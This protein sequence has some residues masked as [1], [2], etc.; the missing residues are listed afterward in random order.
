MFGED[1]AKNVQEL[2]AERVE[3]ELAAEKVLKSLA[4]WDRIPK[5]H[6]EETPKRFLEALHQL[7]DRQDFNF[8]MFDANGLDEMIT[9]GPI[10]FYTLCAHHVVPFYGNVWIGYV[11]NRRIAGLSKFARTVK[12]CAKG[13]W[14]QEELTVEIANFLDSRLDPMGLAVVV[15]AEHMCMAMRGVEASGVITTTSAMRGVFADHSR[16]AKSEFLEWIHNA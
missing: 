7:T 3:I 13:L 9:V 15:K 1:P 5:D 14:V 2:Y 12:W 6:R 10:P 11:P 16:T 4:A 8:T